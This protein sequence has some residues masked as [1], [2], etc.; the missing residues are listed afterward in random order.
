MTKSQRICIAAVPGLF[1]SGGKIWED[2]GERD[3]IAYVGISWDMVRKYDARVIRYENRQTKKN[4]PAT[5][6][7]TQ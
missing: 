1:E 2:G 5:R 7:G 3:A 4:S 6:G